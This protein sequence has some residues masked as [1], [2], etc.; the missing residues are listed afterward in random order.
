MAVDEEQIALRDDAT[1]GQLVKRRKEVIERHGVR[2]TVM[3][4]R[5]ARR[6]EADQETDEGQLPSDR[7]P[8]PKLTSDGCELH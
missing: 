8:P 4:R 5:R 1:V 6:T 2:R 7:Q 3:D